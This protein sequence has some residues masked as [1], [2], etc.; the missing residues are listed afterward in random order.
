M[1]F[2]FFPTARVKNKQLAASL[3]GYKRRLQRTDAEV[4]TAVQRDGG[5]VET[6]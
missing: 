6:V 5:R 1:Y 4:I 3:F 2:F